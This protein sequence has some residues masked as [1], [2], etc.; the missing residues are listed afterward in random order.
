MMLILVHYSF[1]IVH[2]FLVS[3]LI[4][5]S[6][7]GTILTTSKKTK[8]GLCLFYNQEEKSRLRKQLS[9]TATNNRTSQCETYIESIYD[10]IY[11]EDDVKRKPW[12][13]NSS[14]AINTKVLRGL[15]GM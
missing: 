8:D 4:E 13:V 7:L 2:K 5:Q 12:Y 9:K 11:A 3:Y 1:H 6:K 14:E 10:L 15:I